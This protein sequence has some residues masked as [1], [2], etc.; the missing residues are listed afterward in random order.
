VVA[1]ITVGQ[2]GNAAVARGLQEQAA[3]F[4]T[5]DGADITVPEPARFFEEP[6]AVPLPEGLD[7]IP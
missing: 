3:R 7:F 4:F 1:R 6:L 5:A 2:A